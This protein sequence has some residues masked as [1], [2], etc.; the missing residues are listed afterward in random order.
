MSGRG[1]RRQGPAS[2]GRSRVYRESAAGP[3][4]PRAGQLRARGA[5]SAPPGWSLR[6][7][8]PGL[9]PTSARSSAASP[10]PPGPT[11]RDHRVRVEMSALPEGGTCCRGANGHRKRGRQRHA[12]VIRGGAQD[13]TGTPKRRRA[14]AS[15]AALRAQTLRKAR[16]NKHF[17]SRKL[18]Q[19][20]AHEKI[21]ASAG[22][23]PLGTLLRLH[24]R[25]RLLASAVVPLLFTPLVEKGRKFKGRE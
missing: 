10:G 13:V 2:G 3:W 1:P 21:N 17:V 8:R 5:P 14:P 11:H 15:G 22:G 19:N 16:K 23:S 6:S 24:G 12:C 4:G 25:V 7:H 18:G 20:P 9:P